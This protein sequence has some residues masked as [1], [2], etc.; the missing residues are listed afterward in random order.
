MLAPNRR[1]AAHSTRRGV[2]KKAQLLPDSGRLATAK[3]LYLQIEVASKLGTF[4]TQ[5]ICFLDQ[6]CQCAKY[7]R[8]FMI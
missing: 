8:L 1:V 7:D 4:A 2:G 5:P 3:F 6:N